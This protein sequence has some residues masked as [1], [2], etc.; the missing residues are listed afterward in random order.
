MDTN[1][2]AG[3]NGCPCKAFHHQRSISCNQSIKFQEGARLWSDNNQVLQKLPEKGIRFITQFYNA[4]KTSSNL[5][6]E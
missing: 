1:T 6:G 5:N 3:E 4:D 2:S